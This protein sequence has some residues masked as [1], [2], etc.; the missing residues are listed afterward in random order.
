M[1]QAFSPVSPPQVRMS[2]L[3][4]Q[5]LQLCLCAFCSC[6]TSVKS[7]GIGVRRSTPGHSVLCTRS[8][9][10]APRDLIIDR[11]HNQI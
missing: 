3:Q 5:Y 6:Y 11:H 4:L 7:G 8:V 9:L 1:P 2:S 10:S